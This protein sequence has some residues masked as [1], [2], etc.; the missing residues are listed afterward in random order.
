MF[1]SVLGCNINKFYTL[2]LVFDLFYTIMYV[3]IIII[4]EETHIEDQVPIILNKTH[5]YK[6]LLL[7]IL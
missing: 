6:Q 7:C 5:P 3:Y 2:N 1:C 4:K